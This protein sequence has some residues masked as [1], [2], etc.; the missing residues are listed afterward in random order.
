MYSSFQNKWNITFFTLSNKNGEGI[1]IYINCNPYKPKIIKSNELNKERQVIM[2]PFFYEKK[3][4]R[5]IN[6]DRITYSI[7]Q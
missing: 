3:K 7:I 4:V 1:L 2:V 6:E 5:V